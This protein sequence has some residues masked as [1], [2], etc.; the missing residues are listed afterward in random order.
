MI[1]SGD[2]NW[3]LPMMPGSKCWCV[4]NEANFAMKLLDKI[5]RI[6]LPSNTAEEKAKVEEFK[7]VLNSNIRYEKDRCP[8]KRGFDVETTMEEEGSPIARRHLIGTLRDQVKPYNLDARGQ[9]RRPSSARIDGSPHVS[10]DDLGAATPPVDLRDIEIVDAPLLIS[11]DDVTSIDSKSSPIR[12]RVRDVKRSFTAPLLSESN[13]APVVFADEELQ[14]EDDDKGL[15]GTEIV[16]SLE[17]HEDTEL[18]DASILKH[19]PPAASPHAP[20]EP[21]TNDVASD[22]VHTQKSSVEVETLS[23]DHL[24][25]MLD[26]PRSPFPELE[27]SSQLRPGTTS[28]DPV[29]ETRSADVS[30]ETPASSVEPEMVIAMPALQSETVSDRP[31]TPPPARRVSASSTDT[32]RMP[33][34]PP[35]QP[36]GKSVA[37][38]RTS[39]ITSS[40]R[41]SS[42][43]S[44][45]DI[46]SLG[47]FSQTLNVLLGPPSGL[48]SVLMGFARRVGSYGRGS[49]NRG[50]GLGASAA[51]WESVSESR[52]RA[53]MPG[54]WDSEDE[55]DSPSSSD[56]DD[57]GSVRET[58]GL[59]KTRSWASASE[60][61]I[62]QNGSVKP[63]GKR[64][65]MNREWTDDD[66]D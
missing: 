14:A 7:M 51:D 50:L 40:F 60:T 13:T 27:A 17:S 54:S 36:P 58:N 6:E 16:S 21:P 9:P 4:D 5:Y 26:S 53:S 62:G 52:R 45:D 10:D 30:V 20:R 18:Q 15:E 31:Q 37:T 64:P 29:A 22:V 41:H 24:E 19:D 3:R 35:T 48:M 44:D 65:E 1:D 38:T 28:P 43:S 49:G 57:S 8:F 32:L 2:K 25:Q 23:E 59:K 33:G 42:I 12:S 46:P 55:R 34:T 66:L 63:S 39:T 11:S 61:A 47:L 56:L